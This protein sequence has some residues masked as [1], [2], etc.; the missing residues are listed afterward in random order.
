MAVPSGEI[1]DYAVWTGS[2]EAEM[3]SNRELQ[4]RNVFVSNR[5]VAI[6]IERHHP[7]SR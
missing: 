5:E 7:N 6:C 4:L 2:Q 1:D 3:R